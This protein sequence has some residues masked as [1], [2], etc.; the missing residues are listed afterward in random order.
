LLLGAFLSYFQ[1][2]VG[3][4]ELFLP[5]A[6]IMALGVML[7]AVSASRARGVAILAVLMFFL[8]LLAWFKDVYIE[9]RSGEEL[10]GVLMCAFTITLPTASVLSLCVC[11][12]SLFW[13]RKRRDTSHCRN[14]GYNLYGLTENRCPECGTPFQQPFI[15]CTDSPPPPPA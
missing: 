10:W 13:P 1:L 9:G 6:F 15:R 12:S 8:N 14:C 7:T 3:F 5:G 4:R 11:V 2:F